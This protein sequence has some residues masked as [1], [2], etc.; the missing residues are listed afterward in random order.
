VRKQLSRL[1]TICCLL[2]YLE[3]GTTMLNSQFEF[4]VIY[5]AL[6]I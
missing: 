1:V 4:S 5:S 3:Q 6:N 2:T